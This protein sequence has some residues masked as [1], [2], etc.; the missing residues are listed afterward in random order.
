MSYLSEMQ[1]EIFLKSNMYLPVIFIS[2]NLSEKES[3]K[4]LHFRFKAEKY[5]KSFQVN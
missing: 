4:R 1:V 3:N 2:L 5:V